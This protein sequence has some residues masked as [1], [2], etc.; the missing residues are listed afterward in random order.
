PRIS[1]VFLDCLNGGAKRGTQAF[2]VSSAHVDFGKLTED[3]GVHSVFAIELLKNLLR[4]SELLHLDL[5][6]RE[7]ASKDVMEPAEAALHTRLQDRRR[8]RSQTKP[9]IEVST[10]RKHAII[11][12]IL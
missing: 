5:S 1:V 3:F 12:R 10:F 6:R 8:V 2:L 7:L 4:R 11:V 9:P